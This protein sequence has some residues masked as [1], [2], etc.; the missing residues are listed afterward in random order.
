MGDVSHRG[1]KTWSH[2]FGRH[3]VLVA[4]F[5]AISCSIS[6]FALVLPVPT[7]ANAVAA[8]FASVYSKYQGARRRVLGSLEPPNMDSEYGTGRDD[9]IT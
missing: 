9:P 7:G 6:M 5:G 1:H 2:L 4:M 3:V 8:T